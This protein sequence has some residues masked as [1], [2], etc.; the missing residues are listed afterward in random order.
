ML[1]SKYLVDVQNLKNAIELS[2]NF[3]EVLRRLEFPLNGT[4]RLMVYKQIKENNIPIEHFGNKKDPNLSDLRSMKFLQEYLLNLKP[5]AS[6]KLKQK[7]L[8]ESLLEKKCSICNREQWLNKEIPLELDHI[9]GIH[10]DNSF[11]NL[12]LICGN[13]HSQTRNWKG[14]NIKKKVLTNKCKDCNTTILRCNKRCKKCYLVQNKSGKP[15]EN[16]SVQDLL[17]MLKSCSKSLL[18]KKLKCSPNAIT[19][20]IK[21]SRE[22]F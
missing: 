4:A 7:L 2:V 17:E 14:R 11:L 1:K 16:Y 19:N 18:A 21:R 8:K 6:N 3:S 15:L 22:V 10:S 20:K 12:R 5:V 9:N 13:C